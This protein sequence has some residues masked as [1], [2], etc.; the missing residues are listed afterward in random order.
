MARRKQYAVGEPL[1][2]EEWWLDDQQLFADSVARKA[3]ASPPRRRRPRRPARVPEQDGAAGPQYVQG[4]LPWFEEE[5]GDEDEL[6]RSDGPAALG[7]VAA[8][9]V[10]GDRGSGQL[11]RGPGEP[12]VGPDRGAGGPVRGRHAAGRGIPGSGGQ[13]RPGPPSGGGD[14]AARH[15]PAGT[16][17]GSRRGPGQLTSFR[18]GGQGDLAPSGAVRRIR[19]NLAALELLRGLQGSG[20]AGSAEELAVLGRWSG[21]G[22]VPEVFDEARGE[23]GWVRERLAGLLSAAELSAARRTTLN[24]HYTGAALVKAIWGFASRLGFIGGKVL[25]P[26]CGSGNFIAFAPRE[27]RVTGG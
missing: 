12:G 6:L 13:A 2:G 7:P 1:F 26:G 19:A 11:L 22:A 10:R 9:P 17:A 15:D 14:R 18:P 16:G 21:W 8:G 25:E 5:P 20:R 3:Q 24:A 27:A 23:F 4:M